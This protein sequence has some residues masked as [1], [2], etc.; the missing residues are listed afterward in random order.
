MSAR[1]G[2]NR[3]IRDALRVSILGKIQNDNSRINNN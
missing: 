2:I 3:I 1:D